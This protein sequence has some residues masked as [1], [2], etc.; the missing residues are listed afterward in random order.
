MKT[1]LVA[2]LATLTLAGCRSVAVE[3]EPGLAYTIEVQ[4]ATSSNL[5]VSYRDDRGVRELGSVAAGARE[6]FVVAGA[7]G[8]TVEV[9]GVS[10]NATR[11]TR[12]QQ[13]TLVAGVTVP[14][15]LS[16]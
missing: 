9:Y 5:V 3:N 6:R 14:V 13:V 12:A 16:F 15:R 2:A 1:F 4:N 8:T 11:T 10:S 7:S